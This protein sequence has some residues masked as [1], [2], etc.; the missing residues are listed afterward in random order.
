[1]PIYQKK[2]RFRRIRPKK[3]VVVHLSDCTL[4]NTGPS[5]GY[6]YSVGSC[7]RVG[8]LLGYNIQRG[9]NYYRSKPARTDGLLDFRRFRRLVRR[10]FPNRLPG[11]ITPGKHLNIFVFAKG[12]GFEA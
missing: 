8:G 3:P 6:N 5:G 1:M 9:R 2:G 4:H 12:V 7:D 10:P 11:T